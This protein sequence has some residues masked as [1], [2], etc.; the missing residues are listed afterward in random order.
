MIEIE[1]SC[2]GAGFVTAAEIGIRSWGGTAC[3]TLGALE[4]R[5]FGRASGITSV[6]IGIWYFAGT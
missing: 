2:R 5:G 6:V 1:G 3:D 4:D